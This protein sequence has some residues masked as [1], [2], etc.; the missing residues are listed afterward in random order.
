MKKT[1]SETYSEF[2]CDYRNVIKALLICIAVVVTPIS[3]RDCGEYC[4]KHQ[5]EWN[6]EHNKMLKPGFDYMVDCPYSMYVL[7]LNLY[8]AALENIGIHVIDRRLIWLK[9]DG[10]YELVKV[11]EIQEEI[12][13]NF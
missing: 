11:P 4:E 13:K 10:N 3:L 5:K 12:K 1:K 8:Q 2:D 6:E 7:Q 9:P